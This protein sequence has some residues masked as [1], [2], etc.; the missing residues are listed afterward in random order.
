MSRNGRRRVARVALFLTV[1]AWACGKPGE[2]GRAADNPGPTRAGEPA[3]PA[4]A[5]TAGPAA[6]EVE[7]ETYTNP[8]LAFSID[9]PRN[10]AAQA[11]GP[12]VT[13]TGPGWPTVTVTMEELA[14]D[15]GLERSSRRVGGDYTRTVGARHRRYTCRCADLGPHKE[16]VKRVCESLEPIGEPNVE[17]EALEIDGTLKDR[18]AYEQG[19]RALLP[20]L[21]ACWKDALAEDPHRSGGILYGMYRFRADGSTSQ[22]GWGASFE[23]GDLASLKECVRPI[24]E[25]VKTEATSEGGAY[26]QATFRFSKY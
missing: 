11:A 17:L 10:V 25:G 15:E 20:A 8:V 18:A 21:L 7:L 16:L 4:A 9:K 23:D 2:A 14:T 22:T 26:V 3:L 24:Y 5:D 19:L 1:G 13:L 12:T 6:G